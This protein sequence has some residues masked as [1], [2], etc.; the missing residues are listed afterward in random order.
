MVSPGVID[1]NEVMTLLNGQPAATFIQ[2]L[3]CIQIH[4]LFVQVLVCVPVCVLECVCRAPAGLV[5]I[6]LHSIHLKVSP[7]M[8]S[9]VCVMHVSVYVCL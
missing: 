7:S 5:H 1:G 2:M 8:L 6:L 3:I 4:N 9:Y